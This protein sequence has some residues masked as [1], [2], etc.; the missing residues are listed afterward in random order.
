MACLRRF[1]ELLGVGLILVGCG[2]AEKES[3]SQLS[4]FNGGAVDYISVVVKDLRFNAGSPQQKETQVCYAV[5]AGSEGFPSDPSR[6]VLKGCQRVTSTVASFLIEE[7][8]PSVDGYVVSLFQD[9]NMN[10]KLDTRGLFGV[11]VPEEPFGFSQ[12]PALLGAPTYEKCKIM[13]Q[14]NGERFEILM[15]KIGG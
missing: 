9:M 15:R 1:T 12:N 13:P 7:L 4:S 10:G 3:S 5:F 2:V 8:P 11:Q 6:V 14:K